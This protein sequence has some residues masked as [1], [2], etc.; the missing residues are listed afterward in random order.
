M[1]WLNSKITNN[2]A[3]TYS[4][5]IMKKEYTCTNFVQF[6]YLKLAFNEF[7]IGKTAVY[8]K[9]VLI[10]IRKICIIILKI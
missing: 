6:G 10:I 9:V 7:F 8:W 2:F 1:I 4:I 3:N 5:E